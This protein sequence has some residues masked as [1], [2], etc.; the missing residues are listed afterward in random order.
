MM[1]SFQTLLSISTCTPTSRCH[2]AKQICFVHQV[3]DVRFIIQR[4]GRVVQ[5]DS[6]KPTLKP[7]GCKR[8]KLKCDLLLSNFAFKISLRRYAMDGADGF[9]TVLSVHS[10]DAMPPVVGPGRPQLL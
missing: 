8:L 9:D 10:G 5:V 3:S 7:P 1:D 4:H 2:R 6:I